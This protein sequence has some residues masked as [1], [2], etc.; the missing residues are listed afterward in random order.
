M[1]GNRRII[2]RLRKLYKTLGKPELVDE[3]VSE[4]GHAYR[5][6][7]RVAIFGWINK[8]IKNDTAAVKDADFKEL[9][10]TDLRAFPTDKD[11]PA[12]ALNGKIDETFVPRAVVKLPEEGK[13]EAWKGALV[14]QLREQSFRTF[15]EQV[16]EAKELKSV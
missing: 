11:V 12:D 16:P 1:D 10:G 5:P 15:P 2:E 3:Y 13:F 8:H 4:G 6:D 7:L 14:K 9:P